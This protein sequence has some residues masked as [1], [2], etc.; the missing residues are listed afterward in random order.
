M[1]LPP[2]GDSEAE[3][4]LRDD[5]LD[6][7]GACSFHLEFLGT[8]HVE[9]GGLEPDRISYFPWGELRGDLFLHSLLSNLVG[10]LGIVL[11]GR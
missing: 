10:S 8:V 5:F 3:G 2:R 11:G 6:L 9:V 1:N 4:R 7:K